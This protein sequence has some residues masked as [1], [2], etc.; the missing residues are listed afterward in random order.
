MNGS[1]R[2]QVF[3]ALGVWGLWV[4]RFAD[5]LGLE[6]FVDSLRFGQSRQGSYDSLNRLIDTGGSAFRVGVRLLVVPS[7]PSIS[8]YSP[9]RSQVK[10][11]KEPMVAA[12]PS[13]FELYIM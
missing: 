2:V 5:S 12:T 1:C 13:Q 6:G 10:R 8:T 11:S 4:S 9:D 7:A 3:G